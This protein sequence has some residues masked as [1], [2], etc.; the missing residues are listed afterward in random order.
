MRA[1][2]EADIPN[3]NVVAIIANRADASGIN[4]ASQQGIEH[5]VLEHRQFAQREA[6]DV[7]LLSLIDHYQADFVILAGFM[8]VLSPRF[9]AH[10]PQQ[11][12]NIHPSLLPAFPGLHTHRRALAAGCHFS[13]CTVHFV[14]TQLDH[15]PIIAQA[16]VPIYRDDTEA[17]LSARVLLE[18]HRIYP[19]AVA[20]LVNGHLIVDGMRVYRHFPEK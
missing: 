20:D 11:I 14:T 17:T 15:G 4:W 7:A 6:F 9:V 13:G 16:V 3:M 19:Q 8:R 1:I 10:F 18:E 5:A 2:V 12:I